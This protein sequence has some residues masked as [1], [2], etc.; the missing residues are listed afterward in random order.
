MIEPSDNEPVRMR[1]LAASYSTP[2]GINPPRSAMIMAGGRA[3]VGMEASASG[4]GVSGSGEDGSGAAPHPA[5]ITAATAITSTW[6]RMAETS[7]SCESMKTRLSR[8]EGL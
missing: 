7:K 1:P 3:G 2:S 5:N 6:L 8:H 4:I